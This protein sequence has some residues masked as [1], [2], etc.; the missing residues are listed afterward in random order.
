MSPTNSGISGRRQLSNLPTE[1]ILNI[2]EHLIPAPIPTDDNLSMGRYGILRSLSFVLPPS[3]LQDT[4]ALRNFCGTS[5]NHNRIATPLL[6]R[7]IAVTTTTQLIKLLGALLCTEM[8]SQVRYFAVVWTRDEPGEHRIISWD[9]V[10]SFMQRLFLRA[11]P[12][13]RRKL[14][15]EWPQLVVEN[16]SLGTNSSIRFVCHLIMACESFMTR[17]SDILLALPQDSRHNIF[18]GPRSWLRESMIPRNHWRTVRLRFSDFAEIDQYGPEF[19]VIH[20]FL[21]KLGKKLEIC[22]MHCGGIPIAHVSSGYFAGVG[23]MLDA[24]P[25]LS[26]IEAFKLYVDNTNTPWLQSF[27]ERSTNLKHV[28]IAFPNYDSNNEFMYGPRRSKI[29][30]SFYNALTVGSDTRTESLDLSIL[31]SEVFVDQITCLPAFSALKNLSI[32]IPL[33]F[34]ANI[35]DMPRSYQS[36]P[37]LLPLNIQTLTLKEKWPGYIFHQY[38]QQSTYDYRAQWMKTLVEDFIDDCRQ[39]RMPALNQVTLE[40]Y[41]QFRDRSL[42]FRTNT[43]MTGFQRR[44][45]EIGIAFSWRWHR[46]VADADLGHGSRDVRT[47][48]WP[49]TNGN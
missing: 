13:A 31:G 10:L 17:G 12:E 40:A 23:P 3:H 37:N 5:K 26:H 35:M 11:T 24:I 16:I 36:L 49:W 34:D 45:R 48:T 43:G 44:F 42:D 39:E 32:E 2:C 27:M 20:G 30:D 46:S 15:K 14:W 28:S 22:D 8:G 41:R 25:D 6:Y 38:L 9:G 29:N 18:N 47:S 19:S 4:R 21:S 7:N 33:L 1:M